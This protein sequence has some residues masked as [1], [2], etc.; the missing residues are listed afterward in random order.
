MPERGQQLLSAEFIPVESAIASL[1][2]GNHDRC[3]GVGTAFA[4]EPPL[5]V[6]IRHNGGR[7]IEQSR[8]RRRLRDLK[9]G[10]EVAYSQ[11][12]LL[13]IERDVAGSGAIAAAG[14]PAFVA[15]KLSRVLVGQVRAKS[16][17]VEPTAR[18]KA[19]QGRSLP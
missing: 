14:L 19:W 15:W 12:D 8:E 1:R 9:S 2:T 10:K 11:D 16:P 17:D 6:K 5:V 7:A 3:L 18:Q 4:D 13:K